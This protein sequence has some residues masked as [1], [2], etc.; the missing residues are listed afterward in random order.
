M[1]Q[2]RS[3][4][5]AVLFKH[6]RPTHYS[7]D[8]QFDYMQFNDLQFG[9]LQFGDLQFGDLHHLD[10]VVDKTCDGETFDERH[11]NRLSPSPFPS[12]SRPSSL[13]DS[14]HRPSIQS[15][16]PSSSSSTQTL[17]KTPLGTSPTKLI[18]VKQDYPDNWTDNSFLEE[19]QRNGLPFVDC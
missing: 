5:K 7:H 11:V 13:S 6:T 3:K 9:D 1:E 17:A 16:R 4:H 12:S 18:Q 8:F 10:C 14:L 2:L 19:L 15:Q